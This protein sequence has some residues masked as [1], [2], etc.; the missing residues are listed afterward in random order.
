M[1]SLNDVIQ[2]Y[3]DSE[4]ESQTDLAPDFSMG[5]GDEDEDKPLKK[6]R[7]SR[8]VD[9]EGLR[10]DLGKVKNDNNRYF[11]ISVAMIILLFVA[12]LIVVL[13]NLDRPNIVTAVMTAFGASTSGLIWIMIKLWREKSNTEFL[14]ALAI[15]M[16]S[17][18]LTK[19][20]DILAKR[21][22]N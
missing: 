8:S 18:T 19:I 22:P 15:N 5:A 2:R 21:L 12:S 14:L 6:R 9:R 11:L 3:A 20:I 4:Y 1:K 17:D 16:D 7:K 13:T 10:A